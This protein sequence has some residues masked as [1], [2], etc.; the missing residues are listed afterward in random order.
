MS[1]GWLDVVFLSLASKDGS[2]Y[3][4]TLEM[5]QDP[6]IGLVHQLPLQ[7]LVF[8]DCH[9]LESLISPMVNLEIG[10]KQGEMGTERGVEHLPTPR[11]LY[12]NVEKW[13]VFKK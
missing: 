9:L 12:T 10:V 3:N 5:D 4:I 11:H 13:V 6:A 1:V 2:S 8:I 7:P